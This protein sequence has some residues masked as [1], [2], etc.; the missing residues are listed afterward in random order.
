[1]TTVYDNLLS[2][3]IMLRDKSTDYPV[4][5][6]LVS[7]GIN[8]LEDFDTAFPRESK[9]GS[10]IE[11][12]KPQTSPAAFDYLEVAMGVGNPLA[13]KLKWARD[14]KV[15]NNATEENLSLSYIL[16]KKLG[17]EPGGTQKSWI[18]QLD[19]IYAAGMSDME[20]IEAGLE[21]A[22]AARKKDNLTLGSPRSVVSF[23]GNARSKKVT[24]QGSGGR[25]VHG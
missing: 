15:L 2:L 23:V 18:R 7:A 6:D 8:G 13:E 12:E 3:R 1:M 17:F 25:V 11:V 5:I 10:G 22:A 24:G 20:S 4:M 19:D 14:Y 9:E 21:D 16:F